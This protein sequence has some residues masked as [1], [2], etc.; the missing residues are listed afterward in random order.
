M[1][2]QAP[3]PRFGGPGCYPH[4]QGPEGA[5]ELQCPFCRRAIR[6]QLNVGPVVAPMN[7]LAAAA[8]A[9]AAAIAAAAAQARHQRAAGNWQR[10]RQ[11]LAA[12]RRHAFPNRHASGFAAEAAEAA[13][14]K[15]KRYVKGSP[16]FM[17][18]LQYKLPLKWVI[19][20]T[21]FLW[22][23]PYHALGSGGWEVPHSIA[24][25]NQPIL[26]GGFATWDGDTL[27]VDNATGHY[28]VDGLSARQHA[29]RAWSGLGIAVRLSDR[30]HAD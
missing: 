13:T 25:N 29:M 30:L 11:G 20:T 4:C 23:V 19:T 15:V 16:M 26:C 2:C 5:V 3:R 6:L 17:M 9:A 14:Y 21:G 28:R 12:R 24:A 7:A 22:V 8:A 10:L 1:P 18:L 27:V